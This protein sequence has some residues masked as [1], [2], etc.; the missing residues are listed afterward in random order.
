MRSQFTLTN[1]KSNWK[2]GLTIALITIPL[3]ISLAVASGVSPV[4]G[5]ITALWAGGVAALF[6][7]SNYNI[8]APTGALAG[9]IASFASIEGVGAVPMLAIASGVFVLIAFGLKL[10]RYL[11]FIPSSVI[12][13]FIVGIAS[14]IT[15]NQINFA[16]GLRN[17]PSHERL[18][19]RAIES[20]G[21][22]GET[23]F[24]ALSLFIVFFIALWVLRRIVPAIP[25]VIIV[26][27]I[28]IAVGYAMYVGLLPFELE[29]MGSKFGTISP[30]LIQVPAFMISKQLLITAA[31]IA[32]IAIIETMLAA[33]IADA[34]TKTKYNP[35]KEIFGLG[36]ANIASGLAGGFPVTAALALTT[37]NIRAGATSRLSALLSSFFIAIC[38]LLFL[39]YF[40]YMPMAIIAAILVYVA[41]NMVEREH[42]LRIFERD[43][44]NFMIMLIVAAI[45]VY[46]DPIIGILVGSVMA[47]LLV[48]HKLAASFSQGAVHQ[49][50]SSDEDVVWKQNALVYTFRGQLVYFNSQAHLE[51]FYSNFTQHNC[52]ILA[53]ND[54]FFIDSDGVDALE[55]IIE[56]IQNRGQ[57]LILVRPSDHIREL[58][59]TG[60]KFRALEQEGLVFD[61][62]SDALGSMLS[63]AEKAFRYNSENLHN[64]SGRAS[65]LFEGNG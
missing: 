47:L 39:V 13:G 62:L 34:L 64:H 27:P 45:T 26:S 24:E 30:I 18:I 32:L 37:S 42:V 28:G 63:H 54:L 33:K 21:H 15:L 59:R 49:V 46:Q 51:Q 10:E 55:E 36:L 23:S 29:T 7:G 22:L 14:I 40:S 43:K 52:I 35:R 38:S 4:A 61:S 11:I 41:I 58:V 25:G 57:R 60:I 17:V 5:I 9:I 8:I 19:D 1:L 12:H 56:L 53:L 2:S 3:A 20:F 48:V 65:R 44:V 6:G 50:P 31:V 16:L